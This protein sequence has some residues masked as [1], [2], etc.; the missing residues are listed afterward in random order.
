MERV[1]RVEETFRAEQVTNSAVE[2][3][4]AHRT[5]SQTLELMGKVA[6]FLLL[7]I[8]QL[9]TPCL[10]IGDLEYP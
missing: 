7:H 1:T 5:A 6:D 2:S 4:A 8:C 3:V 10:A 9:Q